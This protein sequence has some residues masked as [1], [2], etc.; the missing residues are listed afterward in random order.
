MMMMMM[1]MI[2]ITIIITKFKGINWYF[3]DDDDD[4]NNNNNNNNTIQGYS[5]VF[6][7]P[8][9]RLSGS[10]CALSLFYSK[11][12]STEQRTACKPFTTLHSLIHATRY[13]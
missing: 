7:I 2:I 4:N 10:Q 3:N 12:N 1:M 8:A 6:Q 11:L 13:I 9:V 5:L